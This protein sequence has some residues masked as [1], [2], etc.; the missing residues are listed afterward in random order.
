MLRFLRGYEKPETIAFYFV[1]IGAIVTALPLPFIFVMPT[2]A[3]LPLIL[4]LGL[5]GALAQWM[6]SL[7]YSLAPVAIVSVLNYSGIIWATL[8][9]WLV[10]SDWPADVVFIGA[11]VVIF[12]NAV[13]VWRESR[14]AA[15]SS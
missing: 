1:L 14:V 5:A 7:A 9:G 11:A 3:E 8:F 10:F 2:P 12:S 13:V 6:L 4:G 15:R